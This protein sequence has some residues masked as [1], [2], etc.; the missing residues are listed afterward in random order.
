MTLN[1]PKK[2]IYYVTFLNYPDWGI[3]SKEHTYVYDKQLFSVII[4]NSKPNV[5]FEEIDQAT[6]WLHYDQ[7]RTFCDIGTPKEVTSNSVWI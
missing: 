2:I 1:Y 7:D 3:I 4:H 5:F 6:T